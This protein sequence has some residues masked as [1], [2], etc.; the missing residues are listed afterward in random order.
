MKKNIYVSLIGIFFSIMLI[1]TAKII[2][3]HKTSEIQNEKYEYLADIV[4]N[5]KATGNTEMIENDYTENIR[6]S[7]QYEQVF[8]Q[9]P[10]M[11]GWIKIKDTRINYPVMQS[12]EKPN[13]YLNHGFDKRYTAYG[14]PY[15]QETCDVNTPSDNVL[16]YG[17]HM[18]DGSMFSALD[19]YKSK[20]FWEE[21]KTIIFNTLTQHNDYEI[22]AVFKTTVNTSN[23]DAFKYYHFTNADTK[24]EFNDYIAKCK[25]LSFY[26]TG[27]TAEYGDKLITLST[28]EYSQVNGRIVVVAKLKK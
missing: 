2:S 21:H 9:N 14:C 12:V 22:V 17:H 5:T 3:Y 16:I 27:V 1:S 19:D 25:E 24:V 13:F 15:V 11:I 7:E 8:E 10:D 28:C 6:I 26:D 23:K 18:D 4:D 20:N